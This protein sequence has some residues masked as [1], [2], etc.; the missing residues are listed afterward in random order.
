MIEE[1]E[2]TDEADN[3]RGSATE[4]G[5]SDEEEVQLATPPVAQPHL[6][7]S[8]RNRQPHAR[9]RSGEYITYQCHETQLG[10][11]HGSD[12]VHN[13]DWAER[14]S[15]MATLAVTKTYN[16]LPEEISKAEANLLT[17]DKLLVHI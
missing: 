13:S 1:Q 9:F 5:Q 11:H 10:P 12:Q 7:R 4:C 2:N 14:L 16:G 8:M 15:F 17:W 6:R 3:M